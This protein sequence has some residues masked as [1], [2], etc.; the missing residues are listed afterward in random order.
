MINPA[1]TY[2]TKLITAII[3]IVPIEV[4][5]A[6][7][8]RTAIRVPTGR[9]RLKAVFDQCFHDLIPPFIYSQIPHLRAL[10]PAYAGDLV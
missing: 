10:L 5:V 4:P 8:I 7:E 3:A 9:S 1:I 6:K 2:S